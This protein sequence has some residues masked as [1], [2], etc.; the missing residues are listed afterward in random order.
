VE[1]FTAREP[2]ALTGGFVVAL[3]RSG[4]EFQIPPGRSILHVLREG[5]IEVASSCEEG[6][7]AACETVVL[8]GVPDHRDSILSD[9]ER[10]SNRSM[11]ICCSGSKTPRLVLDL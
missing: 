1:Y 6:V 9:S 10:A 11:L 7:C 3:K 4:C 8:D 2:A 5:G